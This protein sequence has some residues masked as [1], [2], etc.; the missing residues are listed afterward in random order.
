MRTIDK[1]IRKKAPQIVERN[2]DAAIE[3]ELDIFAANLGHISHDKCSSI[4]DNAGF[5]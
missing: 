3:V 2:T 1:I 5:I 4:S